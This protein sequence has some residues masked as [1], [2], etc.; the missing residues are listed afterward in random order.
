MPLKPLLTL[1]TRLKEATKIFS[2]FP[3]SREQKL[4]VIVAGEASADIHGSNLVKAMKRLDPGI[5]FRGIGGNEMERAGVKLLFSASDMAVVGV[6]EVLSR[7]HTIVRASKKL[8]SILK[9]KHPDLL[10][11]IDYPDFNIHIAG[12]AKRYEV[13]VLYYISPQ[14]WAWRK[15]RVRKISRRVDRMAVILPFEEEFYRRRGMKVDYVGHPLLDVFEYRK[16]RHD[17]VSSELR[18]PVVGLLPGSRKEEVRNLLPVMVETARLLGRRYS[19]IR[20]VLPLAPTIDP[21]FLESFIHDSPVEIKVIQGDVHE[22][23]SSCDVALVAS[24]TAT[25]DTAIMGVPMAIVYKVSLVSY[26]VGRMVIKVPHI[27]LVN[28]VAGEEVVPELIQHEVTAERLAREVEIILEDR[29][30]R[31]KMKDK[32][33]RVKESLGR[34]GASE[35]TAGIALEMMR[36]DLTERFSKGSRQ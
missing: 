15:G 25:L 22:V 6:T 10:I 8:K 34:G 3:E 13:P 31:A 14:V 2:T 11:L 21:E 32:L 18:Y 24:G 12:I 7:L 27:G 17:S 23:L 1:L 4:V 29:E 5:V 26:L 16:T 28:L 20:C 19:E 9:Y 30:V 36:R 33:K 35:R